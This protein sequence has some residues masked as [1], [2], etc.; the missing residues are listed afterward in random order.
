MEIEEQ[1]RK[2]AEQIKYLNWQK[3]Q[4]AL[5]REETLNKQVEEKKML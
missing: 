1:L 3:E 2:K 5:E 4:R